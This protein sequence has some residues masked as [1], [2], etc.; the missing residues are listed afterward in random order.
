M[1]PFYFVALP[2]GRVECSGTE[3]RRYGC[4]AGLPGVEWHR[5]AD[6]LLCVSKLLRSLFG[7]KFNRALKEW[8]EMKLLAH[9]LS[10]LP[11][12]LPALMAGPLMMMANAQAVTEIGGQKIVT[13]TRK[14]ASTTKPEFTSVVIAPGRG[15]EVL[16]ITANF[17]GKGNVDVLATPSLAEA[18]KMLDVDDT[19]N[20]D[21]GYRIG[22][23][24]LVP[25][26]N[27]ILGPLSADGKTLTT[28]W[29]GPCRPTISARIRAPC[30]TRC[31]D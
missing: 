12:V 5:R 8:M 23:A 9:V 6:M 10:L 7:G 2:G 30:A 4:S 31:T 21:L 13:L 3:T 22:A 27:R 11:F 1:N 26:P 19:A 24:F 20:G 17:P 15:M 16:Q 14:A 18:K 29:E 25:Y 28:V